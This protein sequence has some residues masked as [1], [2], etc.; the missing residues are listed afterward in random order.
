MCF[1]LYAILSSPQVT[2][3]NLSQI[4]AGDVIVRVQIS[5]N[6]WEG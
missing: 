5:A 3:N 6:M 4:N 2:K 1:Y